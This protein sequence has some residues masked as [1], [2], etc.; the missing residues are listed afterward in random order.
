MSEISVSVEDISQFKKKMSFEIPWDLVKQELDKVYRNLGKKAKI[1]GFRPGKTPRKVLENYFKADAEGEAI[2][3]IINKYYWRELDNRGLVSLSQPEIDQNGLK[4]ESAFCF[5]AAFEA[6]PDFEP[7]GYQELE[8]QKVHYSPSEEDVSARLQV[9][10]KTLATMQEAE[11]G[12]PAALGDFVKIDFAG[13]LDGEALPE[14]KSDNYFLELG[15]KNFIPGFEE[16]IAGMKKDETKTFHITFPEDYA[17]KKMAGKEVIFTVTL[18]E[19]QEQKLPEIN[20]EFVKNFEKYD[21]LEELKN[22]VWSMLEEQGRKKTDSEFRDAIVDAILKANEFSVPPSLV[23]RQSFYMMTDMQK[24]MRAAGMDEQ[25]SMALSFRMNDKFREEA[26][27]TV[28]TY[29]LT[30]KIAEKE[31]IVVDSADIDNWIK[32]IAAQH[33]TDYENVKTTYN[34]PEYLDMLK[35]EII[36]KKV[37]DFIESMANIT[38]VEKVGIKEEA[39]A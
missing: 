7:H 19:L 13:L 3:N 1:K 36:Q 32:E 29:L 33:Q 17:G 39:A 6:E 28:K 11:E 16:E 31:G 34:N 22:D 2:T 8:L 5:S 9:L 20:E 21:T 37:F 35:P 30:K 24:R 10:R 26:E 18:K 23:E 4:E 14:L 15:S 27:K 25:S 12:R 38:T